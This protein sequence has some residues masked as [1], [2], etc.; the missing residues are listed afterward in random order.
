MRLA[1]DTGG[2]FTDLAVEESSGDVRLFKAPTT[3]D[4]PARGVIDVLGKAAESFD[5]S[6]AALLAN[7]KSF[8]HGTTHALNALVTGNTARTALIVTKGHPDILTL[9]EGGRS[10]PFDF[11]IAYP[12][13]FIPRSLTFEIAERIGPTGDIVGPLDLDHARATI[14]ELSGRDVEAVAV[15]FLWSV[16]NGSHECAVESMLAEQLPGIPVSLSHRVNPILRE[17]RRAVATAIDASLKPVMSTY[18]G[19]LES[20]L[21]EAGYHGPIHVLTSQG[22]MTDI[23][24]MVSTPILSV[25]S[26]PSMAPVGARAVIATEYPDQEGDTVI[27]DTGGTTCDVSLIRSGRIPRTQECWLG[28]PF[29]SDMTGFPSVDVRSVGSGGGSI[30]S[31]D[32]GGVLRVGPQ[33]AGAIPG[34]ACY[35]LGGENVT[36]TD[37]ALLL[38]YIDPAN[39]L[40]GARALDI[41]AATTALEEKVARPLGLDNDAAAFAILEVATEHMVQAINDITTKQGIDP[42]KAICVGG[43]GAA[44]LNAGAI[45][46]RLGCRRLVLPMAGAALS[47][48]GAIEARVSKEFRRVWRAH[49]RNFDQATAS[50]LLADLKGACISFVDKASPGAKPDISFNVQARYPNQIWEID[51]EIDADSISSGSIDQFKSAFHEEHERLFAYCEPE[52]HI[53]ILS[54]SA[55]AEI[56]NDRADSDT[57]LASSQPQMQRRSVFIPESGRTLIPVLA[58]T[59]LPPQETIEG[60]AIVETDL[61]SIYIEPGTS[62]FRSAA[63]NLVVS[64]FGLQDT[65]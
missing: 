53:E 4:N 5:C 57:S 8:V 55:L 63:G 52:S 13:P 10:D 14:K 16:A 6:L 30:A 15:C 65:V 64:P 45:A 50:V 22:A 31:V 62:Y 44:G 61:T 58:M 59:A 2:T 19:D 28:S 49:T 33:S 32:G 17:Y 36:V 27:F 12:R 25:N 56:P 48:F 20:A 7:T 42:S 46:R 60:P 43:G 37:A 11:S 29:R 54:W 35:G 26:G 51:V 23:G 24:E 47:A 9:R 21:I 18:L 40:G 38:G 1:T 34:P 3:P 39:F 41:A